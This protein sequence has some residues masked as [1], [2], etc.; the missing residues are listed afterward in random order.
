MGQSVNIEMT[1]SSQNDLFTLRPACDTDKALIDTYTYAEGMDSI[2]DVHGVTVAVNADD[3]AVGFIRIVIDGKGIANVYPIVTYAAWR[4][5]GV[6]RAL[7]DDALSR[8]GELKL[9]SRG[10]SRGFYEALGFTECDWGEIEPGFS[11]DCS[12]CSWRDECNPCPMRL[13]AR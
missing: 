2:P 5:Y 3:V 9:V 6:G 7:I 13:V 8:F 11:E 4:G 10:S 12:A 1:A